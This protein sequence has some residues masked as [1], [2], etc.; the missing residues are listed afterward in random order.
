MS[1]SQ[2]EDYLNGSQAQNR[3]EQ[4]LSAAMMVQQTAL[5]GY[6]NGG[7]D[8]AMAKQAA[9]QQQ[10]LNNGINNIPAMPMGGVAYAMP[11]PPMQQ[12]P[13]A[14]QYSYNSPYMSPPPS[15]TSVSGTTSS[16]YTP[17]PTMTTCSAPICSCNATT[18]TCSC[19]CL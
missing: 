14:M 16:I 9:W 11:I 19:S 1:N 10:A 13:T 7:P 8:I 5:G 2:R 17:P 15:Y 6:I 18:K 12:I 3:L 4:G